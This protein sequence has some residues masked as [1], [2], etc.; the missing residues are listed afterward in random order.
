M[1]LI[2]SNGATLVLAIQPDRPPKT[3]L[4]RKFSCLAAAGPIEEVLAPL[5]V[6]FWVVF[7]WNIFSFCTNVIYFE[8][9]FDYIFRTPGPVLNDL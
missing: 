8:I 4:T 5:K 6:G 1:S 9:I 2:L 7:Y 3:K